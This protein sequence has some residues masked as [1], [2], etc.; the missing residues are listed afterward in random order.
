V[1]WRSPRFF[2]PPP[3]RWVTDFDMVH[4]HCSRCCFVCAGNQV[5]FHNPSPQRYVF[6]YFYLS[7]SSWFCP[8]KVYSSL[9]LYCAVS[10]MHGCRW[11]LLDL[12]NKSQH[13]PCFLDL[14][15]PPSPFCDGIYRVVVSPQTCGPTGVPAHSSPVLRTFLSPRL[16]ILKTL[17]VP[18]WFPSQPPPTPSL[19][20]LFL[21]SAHGVPSS[22]FPEGPY[23]RSAV[24]GWTPFFL[25]SDIVSCSPVS[26][27]R[28][29]EVTDGRV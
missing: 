12:C 4:L 24:Y 11:S 2:F 8:P 10:P 7:V 22:S 17:Y 13:P 14:N 9:P 20:F 16:F 29:S 6:A 15:P 23:L 18:S 19:W 27:F 1:V 28:W 3:P 25:Y 26:L 21:S 5:L